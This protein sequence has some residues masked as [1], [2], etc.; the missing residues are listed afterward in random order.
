MHNNILLLNKVWD[1]SQLKA[2]GKTQI[3]KI[4]FNELISAIVSTGAFY[5]Y[6]IDF[7]DMSLSDVSANIADIHG[8][9]PKSVTFNDILSTIHPDD[10][11]FV[12]KCENAALAEF[13]TNLGPEKLLSYK[14][15][16]CFRSKMKDGT[17][18]LIN[19]QALMLTLDENGR[20]GKSLNIHT[21]I[22]HLSTRNNYHYSLI[23]LH[24]LP[25]FL[26][27]SVDKDLVLLKFTKRE[28]Q[29]V[30]MIADGFNNDDMATSL[31]LSMETI[32]KHRKNILRKADCSNAPHLIKKCMELGLI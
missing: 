23:G 28:I 12:N 16:Y 32:K 4:Q 20:F 25:S 14:V 27:L 9:D 22:H 8:F 30:K 10:F 18:E 31:N 17:Y 5:F 15:S 2:T 7:F 29:I 11:S 26:N 24:G 19:H 3:S 13:Y 21:R 6:V 1:E